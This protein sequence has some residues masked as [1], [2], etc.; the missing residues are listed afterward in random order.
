MAKSVIM[1][2]GGQ[3]AISNVDPTQSPTTYNGTSVISKP[4]RAW[5]TATVS[6][7]SAA[8]NLVDGQGNAIFQSVLGILAALSSSGPLNYSGYT[9]SGDNKTLTISGITKPGSASK[10]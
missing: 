9:V 2:D 1:N 8:F 6:G 7:S 10:K 5:A 3:G 4:K